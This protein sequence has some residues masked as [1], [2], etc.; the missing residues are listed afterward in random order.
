MTPL[1]LLTIIVGAVYAAPSGIV[2][3]STAVVGPHKGAVAVSGSVSGP[4]SVSGAVSGSAV[5]SGSV[6]GPSAVIGSVAGPTLVSEP[7]L[8]LSALVVDNGLEHGTVIAASHAAT[9]SLAGIP[10]AET[11]V[12]AGPDGGII[13]TNSIAH[14]AVIP[15]V[16][17]LH[18]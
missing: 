2:G 10:L 18:G 16:N 6:A 7:S 15:A 1:I 12:I 4:V 14:G 8:G 5:V 9:A 17:A 3:P 13:S 11:T